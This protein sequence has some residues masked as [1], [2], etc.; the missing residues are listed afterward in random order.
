MKEAVGGFDLLECESLE[1]AI[2]IAAAHP[3]AGAG[4]IEARPLWGN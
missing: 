2:D 1:E 4:A 3:M